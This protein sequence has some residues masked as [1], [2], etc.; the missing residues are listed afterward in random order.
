[1]QPRQAGFLGRFGGESKLRRMEKVRLGIIGLGNIGQYHAAY[2]AAGKVNR[3]EL[4]AVADAVASKLEKYR[5]LKV[6]TDA[7]E[8]IHSGLVDAVVIAT[9]HFQH[10]VLGI[11]AMEHGLHVMVEK[12]I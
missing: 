10:T 5:P 9:P 4:V 6:F 7:E 8:L 12:P 11:A 2:L 1:M 3:A